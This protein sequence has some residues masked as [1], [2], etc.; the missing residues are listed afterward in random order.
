M[1]L[2]LPNNTT[3]TYGYGGYG[4][5]SYG[6]SGIGITFAVS[7]GYGGSPTTYGYG[8]WTLMP[9]PPINVQGGYGGGEYGLGYFGSKEHLPPQVSST[10]SLDGNHIKVFFNEPLLID[11]A[12]SDP[13]NYS[14]VSVLGASVTILSVQVVEDTHTTYA[15]DITHTG[16]SAVILGHTGTT[17][18]G[19]YEVQVQGVK[20]LSHNEINPE[21]PTSKSIVFTLGTTPIVTGIS[22]DGNFALSFSEKIGIG[23]TE[24]ANYSVASSYPVPPVFQSISLRDPNTVD[25]KYLGITTT[26]YDIQVG[27]LTAIALEDDFSVVGSA[28]RNNNKVY[29]SKEQ[30][31]TFNIAWA[32]GTGRVLPNSSFT[33]EFSVDFSKS[34]IRPYYL[35][36]PVGQVFISDGAVEV[37]L[38]FKQVSGQDIVEFSSGATVVNIATTWTKNRTDILL[39]R[40]EDFDIYALVIN[41]VCVLS[42]N[43]ASVTG[44]VVHSTGLT[45]A[46]NSY[47][48]VLLLPIEKLNFTA[49][50]T[51][52]TLSGN[53]INNSITTIRGASSNLQEIL[54]TENGP[55]TKDWGDATPATKQDVSVRI[56]GVAVEVD[57]VNPYKGAI[58]P[59]IPIPLMPVGNIS[60]QID[61]KWHKNPMMSFAG[62]NTEGLT[63]N[64]W[65][66]ANHLENTLINHE[67]IGVPHLGRFPFGAVLPLLDLRPAPKLISHRYIGYE[68][69]YS[70]VLNSPTTMKLN[71]DPHRVAIPELQEIL[72]SEKSSYD[73][74]TLASD[75]WSI[76]GTLVE[77]V[78]G[79]GTFRS[80]G[81]GFYYQD[82]DYSF[83]K[84][85]IFATRFKVESYELFGVFTGISFGIK[86]LNDLYMIGL[87]EVNG[88]KHIGLC[89]DHDKPNEL[90]SWEVGLKHTVDLLSQNEFSILTEDYPVLPSAQNVRFQVIGGTQAGTYT[91]VEAIKQTDGTTTVTVEPPFPADKGLF[92]NS[93][94]VLYFE[95]RFNDAQ[96]YRLATNTDNKE[97]ELYLGGAISGIVLSSSSKTRPVRSDEVFGF[98]EGVFWGSSEQATIL[99]SLTQY[100]T[101][102]KRSLHYSRGLVVAEHFAELPQDWFIAGDYGIPSIQIDEMSLKSYDSYTYNRVEPFFGLELL[103]DTDFFFS[104]EKGTAQVI[105]D[106]THREIIFQNLL[107]TIS[108]TGEKSLLNLRE[109][110]LSGKVLPSA[111]G[112]TESSESVKFNDT[113]HLLKILDGLP[114]TSHVPCNFTPPQYEAKKALATGMLGWDIE[115]SLRVLSKFPSREF[116]SVLLSSGVFELLFELTLTGYRVGT[117]N[118]VVFTDTFSHLD[119]FNTYV[120]KANVEANTLSVIING[121]VEQIINLTPFLVVSS[122]EIVFAT[123]Q[124][125]M[126]D[127]LALNERAP[128]TA[129]RTLGILREGA[130]TDI[131]SWEIPRTDNFYAPNSSTYSVIEEMDWRNELWVRLHRDPS[132]GVTLYRPD[133]V[134]P[135]YFTGEFATET[136]DP[137]AGWVNVEYHDLPKSSRSMGHISFG[138]LNISNTQWDLVRYR[139]YLTAHEDFRSPRHMVLNQYN[140]ITSDERSKD[141]SIE[142]VQVESLSNQ[143]VSLIPANI[144]AN[145]VFVVLIGDYVAPLSAWEFDEESQTVMF[146]RAVLFHSNGTPYFGEFHQHNNTYMVGARHTQTSHETLIY[147]EHYLCQI[148]FS[149][150]KTRTKTYLESQE[151][152]TSVTLLNEGTP[153]V[154]KSQI[155]DAI[156]DIVFGS[157]I[158][159]PQDY[160]NL[161]PDFYLNDPSKSVQFRNPSDAFYEDLEFI[162]KETT[163][164]EPI[165]IACDEFN[166]IE[167]YGTEYSHNVVAIKQ[168]VQQIGHTFHLS[169]GSY[170][171]TTLGGK[172]AVLF[173]NAPTKSGAGAAN[174]QA[175]IY[176]RN[177][178]EDTMSAPSDGGSCTGVLTDYA[179]LYSHIAPWGSPTALAQ[180]SLLYGASSSQPSGIPT[181]GVGMIAQGGNPLPQ[182][183]TTSITFP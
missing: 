85:T 161:D 109:E 88:V 98:E 107:Y 99:W 79:D 7:G 177:S 147:K 166:A 122:P 89:I 74:N 123:E 8:S 110:G 46:L 154:P 31:E 24:I 80:I 64:K 90:A 51:I 92:G 34:H 121:V 182:P 62:L 54:L 111:L 39:V 29:V 66:R 139:L 25:I 82:V 180:N 106:D 6:T 22:E 27:E 160:L 125:T 91:V 48:R 169:G 112:W 68:R 116:P 59:T 159:V 140:V 136:T 118:I 60:V 150:S 49:S 84:S 47:Y 58:Q 43:L 70:A 115:F 127:Y 172:G 45:F 126:L 2:F 83:A 65:D 81:E 162:T 105:V 183:T 141:I 67:P 56:N 50:Q 119:A 77:A 149:P 134:P 101:T 157:G 148:S 164:N 181:S 71:Q 33:C 146:H 41:G 55:L 93:P 94:V 63:L 17:L 144:F 78:I 168:G 135:P 137:S 100:G 128:S 176:I 113:Y 179:N 131:D 124:E 61:Y 1:A 37:T 167:I 44:S 5:T 108:G 38:T 20:D 57:A 36:Q 52:Y 142:K 103:S 114:E 129:K 21:S 19:T 102:P 40:N 75:S 23:A 9:R 158:N 73:G 26:N 145:D 133:L 32:N 120:L 174:R 15:N 28:E 69:D 18:G 72:S 4:F 35:T 13:A 96:T 173:P 97:L 151:L 175:H 152:S 86:T 42:T 87:L 76:K 165:E 143:M 132:W 163:D 171:G 3:S 156:R 155:K 104:V 95:H 53:F 153:P 138:A 16:A 11:S 130:L 12:L 170:S 178:H 10:V 30:G 117:K 14:I